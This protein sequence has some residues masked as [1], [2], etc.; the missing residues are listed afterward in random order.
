MKYKLN[1]LP[2]DWDK[3]KKG[4]RKFVEVWY[5]M[6]VFKFILLLKPTPT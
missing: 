3:F 5:R 6:V 1:V 4:L 2:M